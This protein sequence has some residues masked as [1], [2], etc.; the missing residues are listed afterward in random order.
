MQ[1]AA[2]TGAPSWTFF[3][4]PE[5]NKRAAPLPKP[6]QTSLWD[7]EVARIRPWTLQ[8]LN[9]SISKG[10]L[11]KQ[12]AQHSHL[13]AS[14]SDVLFPDCAGLQSISF[15]STQ[16]L[17]HDCSKFPFLNHPW[18]LFK[19]WYILSAKENTFSLAPRHCAIRVRITAFSTPPCA[20]GFPAASKYLVVFRSSKNLVVPP[21]Q[22]Y[23]LLGPVLQP[24]CTSGC[25]FYLWF[26]LGHANSLRL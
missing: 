8:D 6:N 21:R 7:L 16:L 11:C 1:H 25:N 12:A 5:E 17:T 4:I 13:L 10:N 20:K 24:L 23:G 19:D 22:Q 15:K 14:F 26:G 18:L 3:A 2:S 9:L